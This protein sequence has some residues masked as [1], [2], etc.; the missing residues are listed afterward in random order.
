MLF[1]SQLGARGSVLS[2][3]VPVGSGGTVR[4]VTPTPSPSSLPQ[5]LV[6]AWLWGWL[7][8]TDCGYRQQG[9]CHLL[10]QVCHFQSFLNVLT[11]GKSLENSVV[12]AIP[13]GLEI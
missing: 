3:R 1:P 7:V 5:V 13:Q 9:A 12:L 6:L 10:A 8:R 11:L 2:T 4:A